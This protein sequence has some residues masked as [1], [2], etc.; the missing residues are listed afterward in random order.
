MN[1]KSLQIAEDWSKLG[2]EIRVLDLFCF[3][4]RFALMI[5]SVRFQGES[6]KLEIGV[7]MNFSDNV[8]GIRTVRAY[9]ALV[10]ST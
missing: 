10:R 9:R 4:E 1:Q 3:G 7:L 5:E 8:Y 6:A 2:C